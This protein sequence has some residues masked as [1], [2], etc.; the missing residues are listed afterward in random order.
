MYCIRI[1]HRDTRTYINRESKNMHSHVFFYPE[2][3]RISM[4]HFRLIKFP[5][6]EPIYFCIFGSKMHVFV[7][8][9]FKKSTLFLKTAFD[10]TISW[11]IFTFLR[12]YL[13]II[14]GLKKAQKYFTK[15]EAC[16]FLFNQWVQYVWMRRDSFRCIGIE[17]PGTTHFRWVSTTSTKGF[18]YCNRYAE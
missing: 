17:K 8:L 4:L 16:I 5:K 11:L 18:T 12:V 13:C 15:L 1:F 10:D 7:I 2:K 14:F 6:D 9:F 3:V